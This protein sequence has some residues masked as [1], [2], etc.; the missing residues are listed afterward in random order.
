MT[1]QALVRCQYPKVTDYFLQL[2]AK[3][4]KSVKYLDYELQ[5]L[6]ENARHLPPADLPKLD[7][8]AAKLDEK[9]VDA[10]LVAID[11]LRRAKE[12]N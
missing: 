1:V 3:K 10:F 11:P 2:V 12:T 6:F 9:F 5:F 7:E 4:T 8:F